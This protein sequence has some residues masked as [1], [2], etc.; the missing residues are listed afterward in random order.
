MKKI[1]EVEIEIDT[2]VKEEGINMEL[3]EFT[4]PKYKWNVSV[5]YYTDNYDVDTV[6]STMKS[7]GAREI[8]LSD[9]RENMEQDK[10]NTGIC[11]SSPSKQSIIVI[12]KTSSSAEFM[13][14][15][16]HE[17]KHLCSHIE[18][19]YHID[20]N[21]EEAAYLAGNIAELMFPVAKKYL[22]K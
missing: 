22:E 18:Q 1:K 7:L 19:F 17:Q 8:Y 9:A 11:Y 4:I 2:L 14:S 20:S 15:L 6:L 5:Y 21:S 10:L 16:A 13:N 12:A 3:Q